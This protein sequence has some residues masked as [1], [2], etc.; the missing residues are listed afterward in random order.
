M[1]GN[2]GTVELLVIMLVILLVFGSK[3]IPEIARGLGKG[4]REFKEAAAEISNELR[5]EDAR[6]PSRRPAPVRR[7]ET[8]DPIV[9]GDSTESHEP[10][11]SGG[12]SETQDAAASGS[13]AETLASIMSGGRSETSEP[14]VSPAHAKAKDSQSTS[15]VGSA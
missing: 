15:A 2:I 11:R 4:I 10:V 8:P 3:R 13:R 6:T 5:V 12:P 1:L 9:P 14:V 7:A